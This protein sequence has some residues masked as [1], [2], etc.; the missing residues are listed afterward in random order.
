M[1][2]LL[3]KKKKKTGKL[4]IYDP[5]APLLPMAQQRG[6]LWLASYLQSLQNY[7]HVSYNGPPGP[8]A[9]NFTLSASMGPR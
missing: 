2:I 3:Q 4:N 8:W 6:Q 5:F 9:A 1:E 7:V